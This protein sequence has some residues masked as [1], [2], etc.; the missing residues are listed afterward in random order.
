[1]PT[2]RFAAPI[3]AAVLLLLVAT[4]YVGSYLAIVS[5][6]A[7]IAVYNGPTPAHHFPYLTHYRFGD[8]W[9]PLVFWPLE[10][11]DR[12]LRAKAWIDNPRPGFQLDAF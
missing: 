2:T 1:M 12:R 8:A 3:L 7:R 9:A 11:V 4:V 10:Q 6:Q 5:P